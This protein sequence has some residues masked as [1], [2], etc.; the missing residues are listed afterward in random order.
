[1]VKFQFFDL[2][3]LLWGLI[4][5]AVSLWPIQKANL[6]RLLIL[7]IFDFNR[8]YFEHVDLDLDFLIQMTKCF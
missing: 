2:L 6:D 1:M 5:I 7:S 4:L 8:Q 3:K